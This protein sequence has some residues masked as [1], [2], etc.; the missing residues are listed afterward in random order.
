MIMI[1]ARMSSLSAL[2]V[3]SWFQCQQHPSCN[4]PHQPVHIQNI[5]VFMQAVEHVAEQISRENYFSEPNFVLQ[6][7][8]FYGL[9]HDQIIVFN[10][11]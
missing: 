7:V 4:S 6:S 2:L 11:V 9:Q 5:N 8:I 1:L 3:A 10:Y